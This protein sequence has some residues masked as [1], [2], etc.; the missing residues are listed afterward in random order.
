M[1]NRFLFLMAFGIVLGGCRPEPDALIGTWTVDKVHVQFDESRSTPEL[2]KQ[3]GEMEKRNTFS[4]SADSVLVFKGIDEQWEERVNL[5][6]D[7]VL[8][9]S[10]RDFGI[11]SR[12]RIVTRTGSPLGEVIV[13]YKKE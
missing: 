6:N 13:I 3:T 9:C 10:G 4:I 11:W 12:G 5:V 8:R 7:S 1:K 2:V